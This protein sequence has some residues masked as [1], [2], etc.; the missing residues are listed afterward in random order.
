MKRLQAIFIPLCL[1]VLLAG[2]SPGGFTFFSSDISPTSANVPVDND[3]PAEVG[4]P[5]AA[6]IPRVGTRLPVLAVLPVRFV[7]RPECLPSAPAVRPPV[8]Q[9]RQRAAADP[10][11]PTF[12]G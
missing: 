9:F 10:R 11:A 7:S 12:N 5:A 8:W 6:E 3:D 4:D 1:A 2:N